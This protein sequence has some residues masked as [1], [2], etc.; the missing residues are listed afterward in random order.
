MS[1][2]RTEKIFTRIYAKSSW[3]DHE[4][5]SGAGSGI[6]R[7]E[8]LRPAL[9]RLALDLKIRSLL[10]LPCGD[11]NWMRHTD[12][13]GIDYT[14]IDIVQPLIE[15]NQVMYARPGRRFLR[16]DMLCDTLPRADL[17]LCR[18]G[19]VHLSFGDIARALRRLHD[20]GSQYLLVTTFTA[21]PRNREIATGGWRPLNLDVGPFY[22]PPPICRLTD[23]PQDG[24]YPDKALVLYGFSMLSARLKELERSFL[25]GKL[26]PEALRR[27]LGRLRR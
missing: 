6:A 18:D 27:M 13:T 12:L 10:D 5:K 9:T 8:S 3:G 24:S 17:V 16:L 15:R 25:S 1:P 23:C 26:L 22:F 20:S 7:T 2:S 21:H 11:F 19:L 4:S 14:G